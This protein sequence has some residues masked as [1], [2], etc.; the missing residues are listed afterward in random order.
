MIKGIAHICIAA[1]DLAAAEKFYCSGLGLKKGFDFIRDGKIFGFYLKVSERSFIEVFQQAGMP[2]N[3]N[4]AI[5]HLCLEV[6]DLDQLAQRLAGHGYETT[7]KCLGADHSWQ[8]WVTDPSGV[9]IE[10]HQYTPESSQ[11]TG[12]NCILS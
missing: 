5:R 6:D 3:E 7:K 8:M 11:L 1:A 10:F 4:C 9:K 12:G 2:V